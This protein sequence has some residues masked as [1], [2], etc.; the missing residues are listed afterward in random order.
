[1]QTLGINTIR[2][3]NLNPDLNHDECA[4]IFNAAGM[5]MMLDVNSPLVGESINSR[6]PWESYYDT[7][8]NRTFAVVE[9]FKNYPNTLAFFS[10]NEVIDNVAAGATV[11]PY[12]RAVTRD[13]K[14]YISKHSDRPIP[15][16]YS[17][18]D[19]R[20]V[21]FDTWRYLQCSLD[22]TANDLSHA[23]LF[24]LNSYSWC[25]KS[26]FTESGYDKLVAG[27]TGSNVPI[28]YSEYGCNEV[29][30]RPFD[31]VQSIYSS[32]MMDVFSGGILY[33]FSEEPS[34]YGIVEIQDDGTVKLLQDYH[35]LAQQLAKVDYASIQDTEIDSSKLVTD[36]PQCDSSIIELVGFNRN[37][38]IPALPPN[39]QEIIDNGVSPTPSGQ[40]IPVDDYSFSYKI[41]DVDGS[42]I[43]DM[44]VKALA[45][46]AI[47]SYGANDIDVSNGN[48]GASNSS[49]DGDDDAAGRLSV[50][51]FGVAIAAVG[52]MALF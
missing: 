12:M 34:N 31:E 42:E 4:S 10:G 38:T 37:F 2:T 46:D 40:I 44:M 22:G 3:Y 51:V 29:T 48:G 35:T 14:N 47:N 23:D 49:G 50:P 6:A 13:L 15:V 43:K 11:P 39:T 32:D 26:S 30:P 41:L 17:A 52:V 27:F 36:I 20:D 28:F 33:E 7:Y 16:G 8:L 1:M 19:V 45:D 25:G 5:Y 21:L 24:A 9:A 18:A